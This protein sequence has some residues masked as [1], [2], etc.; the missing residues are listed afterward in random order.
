MKT[1]MFKYGKGSIKPRTPPAH[2]VS[3]LAFGSVKKLTTSLSRGAH[4]W[5]I[6]GI[7][8]RGNSSKKV[9]FPW[10]LHLDRELT[11]GGGA[12]KKSFGPVDNDINTISEDFYKC[13]RRAVKKIK[14]FSETPGTRRGAG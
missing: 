7:L 10:I 9:A 1:L 5:V 12:A 4:G 8:K 6:W 13:T 11:P 3:P 14:R 2:L